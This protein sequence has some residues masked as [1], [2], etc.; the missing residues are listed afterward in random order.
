VK[1]KTQIYLTTPKSKFMKKIILFFI[2]IFAI[3][4][5]SLA[6]DKDTTKPQQIEVKISVD[7]GRDTSKSNV[8][9]ATNIICE[10]CNPDKVK[11][12]QWILVLLP[13][14]LFLLLFFY[15]MGWLKKDKFKIA[16]ALSSC[17]PLTLT[18]QT[19]DA[20]GAVTTTTDTQ[21]IPRSSSRLIAFLAGLTAMIIG[22]SITTYYIFITLADCSKPNLD[23][24]WKVITSLGIGIIPYGANMWK[25]SKKITTKVK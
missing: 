5:I 16:D 2:M 20:A 1:D 4:S 17:E 14:I 8:A 24:M 23:D 21:I 10:T 12:E 3:S 7:N 9:K 15:F 25:E 13:T 18:E 22:L 6:E 19:K 11:K